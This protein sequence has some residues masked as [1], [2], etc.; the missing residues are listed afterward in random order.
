LGWL[1]HEQENINTAEPRR[2]TRLIEGCER[3]PPI[4]RRRLDVPEAPRGEAERTSGH[5]SEIST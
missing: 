5:G 3:A 4:A 1:V 2:T